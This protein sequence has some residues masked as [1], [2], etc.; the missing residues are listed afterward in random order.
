MIE[1]H[2]HHE[3]VKLPFKQSHA[4]IIG[5]NDY[6]QLYKLRTAINDAKKL[7]EILAHQHG[8]NVF[9]PLLNASRKDIDRLLKKTIIEK[10]KKEDRCLFYF[11]G[12]GIALSGEDR[13][14][15]YLMPADAVQGNV[16]SFISMNQLYDALNQLP[17]KH[18]LVI[19]DCCFAGAFKWASRFRYPGLLMPKR[20][21]KERFHRFVKDPAYQVITSAASDQKAM[22]YDLSKLD[23]FEEIAIGKRDNKRMSYSPF[24]EA[25]FKGLA[26]AADIIPTGEGDGLI[27]ASELYL[28]L[29][30]QVELKTIE[31]NEKIRQ[32]PGIFTLEKHDKGEFIFLHP[33]HRLNLPPIPRRNPYKGLQSFEEQ[34]MD[35]FYGRERV[36]KDL[37]QKIDENNLVVVTGASGTGKS[38]VVKAG[39]I[40]ELRQQDYYILP[41]IRPGKN[42]VAALEK[43]LNESKLFAAE[44]SLT[45]NMDTISEKLIR[46]KTLL[47]IDQ[48]EE[49]ITQCKREIDRNYF[50]R[51]L[52]YF[53]DKN[54]LNLF[55][56][57]LTV[58]ADF[59]PQFDGTELEKYWKNSRYPIP[60]FTTEELR[61]VIIKP[62]LQEVLVIEPPGLV[63][64]M[65]DEVIQ[66]PGALPLFS[67]TL[68]ELYRLYVESGR[69]NR[70]LH[71]DD[72]KKLGGVVGALR[73]RADNLYNNMQPEYQATMQKIM[74]RLVSFERGEVS[75]KK[76]LMKE[77]VFSEEENDRVITIIEQLL[78]AHLLLKDIDVDNHVYIEPAHD[79]LIR[80]WATLGHWINSFGQDKI[81]LQNRLSEAVKDYGAIKD[82]NLLW[83]GDPRLELFQKEL[84]SPNSL[85]NKEEES[86]VKESI[87]LKR[88]KKRRFVTVLIGMII[89]LTGSLIF[90]IYKANEATNEAR[91]AR[92][93]YLSSQAQIKLKEEPM[94]A[95]R[96]AEES[97]RL[98]KNNIALQLMID[99]AVST[100][101]HPFYRANIRHDHYINSAVFSPT[102]SRILTASSDDTAKLWDLQGKCITTFPHAN[103]VLSARFSP[104]GTRVLTASSDNTARLWN[105]EG[106]PLAVFP[107]TDIVYSARFSPDGTKILTSSRDNTVKLWDLQGN[108]LTYYIQKKTPKTAEFSPDG[109][110]FITVS[111]LGDARLWDIN[112]KPIKY[113]GSV[114]SAEFSTK[115]NRILTF[116]MFFSYPGITTGYEVTIRGMAG[117]ILKRFKP[118]LRTI[119]YVAFSPDGT[120]IFT[121]DSNGLCGLWNMNGRIL[122][123]FEAHKDSITS[124]VFSPDGTKILTASRDKTAKLWDLNGKLIADFDKHNDIVGS[125]VFSPDGTRVLTI[126]RD[127]TAKLW[128]M[129]EQPSM[130]LRHN[131]AVTATAFSP[132]G[133]QVITVS[134]DNTVK[135]WGLGGNLAANFNKHTKLVNSAEFSPD[136]TKILSASADNTAKLWNRS[137]KLLKNFEHAANV[138]SAVFSPDGDRILTASYDKTVKLWNLYG[139]L[140]TNFDQ[141]NDL[142]HY[143]IF[144]PDGKKILTTSHDKTA[145]IWDLQGQML[146]NLDIHDLSVNRPVFSPDGK[147]II[148]V[149][150]VAR[151]WDLGGKCLAVFKS[152][153]PK[154]IKKYDVTSALFSPDGKQVLTASNNNKAEL[155]DLQGHRLL[156]FTGHK[157]IV[158]SAV[159]SPDGKRILTASVDGTAKMWDLNGNLLADFN[160]HKD[161]VN[162]AVFSPDGRRVLTASAD[163]TVKLWYTP[164]GIIQWLKTDK[165]PKL[166]QE[167]K[168]L[169]GVNF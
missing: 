139:S 90:A 99:A 169:G 130:D 150:E 100:F 138:N 165:I 133:T 47:A 134:D 88:Q 74:L 153:G 35:L 122:P 41:V 148:I 121:G 63:D 75:G 128:D 5:I 6:Q 15:G 155:W 78:E 113:L 66:A 7:A 105:L 54:D 3:P 27:T 154:S 158:N 23:I 39:L 43:I 62:L 108:P 79:A 135:L 85:L 50:I 118:P 33:T 160:I 22:D 26:G 96:L 19:L 141:H 87:T 32:T 46:D 37:V 106:K 36:I 61:E 13:P 110:R 65:I 49:L 143:A 162:S 45:K 152:P 84:Q 53:L 157:G 95:I 21:Y 9:P 151:L 97:Y 81:L 82:K 107:H 117:H 112:G 86:F 109:S 115:N 111:L 8:F 166:N 55:K 67:F 140:I 123:D 17:C 60:S 101:Q 80:A 156:E 127:N 119:K 91:I 164:E 72:Y 68:S 120:K 129:R 116:S 31:I 136:G 20:I 71:E 89:V 146:L 25:L 14:R 52:K 76:V 10:V 147:K 16:N 98:N 18:L 144:S 149:S 73:T 44:V 70:V 56:I 69:T 83:H 40:P 124:V 42:P 161:I 137:G 58:R 30:E 57:I 167:E 64:R 12:H 145:K 159:F 77:L 163:K 142:L 4:F 103:T 11:A 29:R 48:Y 132:D 168:Y 38:S 125:A 1:N 131:D 92:S 2:K 93:N 34:D 104:G 114:I 94:T 59:E 28:Y 126:S 102:G 51:V 24:A